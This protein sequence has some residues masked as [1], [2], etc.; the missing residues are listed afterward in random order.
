MRI[1]HVVNVRWFNATA[2]Y[3]LTLSRL[4]KDAGHAVRVITSDRTET[5][6]KAQEL[7]LDPFCLPLNSLAPGNILSSS[8]EIKRLIREFKPD[9]VNCHRGESFVLWGYF[10]K[11]LGSFRLVRTRGDQRFPKDNPLNRFLHREVADAVITTNSVMTEHFTSSLGIPG[12]KVHQILGGVDRE[13][14]RFDPPGRERVRREF[15]FSPECKVLGIL[16]RFDRVKGHL[17]LIQAV[18]RLYFRCGLKNVRLLCIGFDTTISSE[19]IQ[20]WLEQYGIAGITRITGLRNDVTACISALDLGVVASLWSEAIARAALE[21]MSC[22][23]PLVG[24]TVGVMPD[25]L[26]PERLYPPDDVDGLSRVLER[27]LSD[28]T[29]LSRAREEQA[30]RMKT[31]SLDEFLAATLAVYEDVQ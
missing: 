23:I 22:S 11:R 4:L 7:G 17:E 18:S 27:H 8:I 26:T 5:Y 14:F 3:G 28:A 21:I 29:E 9:V 2:W 12:D 31:L 20:T 19:Q 24:S 6:Q 16:G 30:A 13:R 10:R 1:I 15:G 25:L